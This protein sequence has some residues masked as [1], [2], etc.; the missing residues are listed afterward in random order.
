MTAMDFCEFRE[1]T[2]NSI[3]DYLPEEFRGYRCEIKKIDKING[4]RESMSIQD[5]DMEYDGVPSLY[6]D[7]FYEMYRDC[8]DMDFVMRSAAEFYI[9]GIRLGKK[10]IEKLKKSGN[11]NIIMVLVNADMNQAI[12][13]DAPHRRI[14]DLAV[15]Y[16]RM[17]E[18][19]D[20]TFNLV[21]VNNDEAAALGLTE[22]DLFFLARANTVRLLPTDVKSL[23]G[24]VEVLSNERGILGAS[25]VLYEQV[26]S[27]LAERQRND[28]YVI[29]SS[30]H[31]V[32]TI[33]AGDVDTK[34]LKEMIRN[35]NRTI[36]R[37]KDILSDNLY[38]FSRENRELTL[39]CERILPYS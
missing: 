13:E 15:F 16:R 24:N 26:L 22:N 2:L 9:K 23:G 31:E 21:T 18:C 29:P 39:V 3:R 32:I 14:L 38:H 37:Q 7:D 10:Y 19:D 11:D 5:P 34:A 28:L 33:P 35:A 25:A 8:R 36:L 27:E 12:L 17:I 6:L 20:G 30:I 1:R 4:S